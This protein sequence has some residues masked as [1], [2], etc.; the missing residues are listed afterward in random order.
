MTLETRPS[1]MIQYDH[2]WSWGDTLSL[3]IVSY[4][5]SLL[6]YISVGDCHYLSIV[7]QIKFLWG[8]WLVDYSSM[9]IDH[10]RE[11]GFQNPC[12]LSP[13]NHE[14]ESTLSLVTYPLCGLTNQQLT[15]DAHP[16]RCPS[17]C[18]NKQKNA[19]C[20]SYSGKYSSSNPSAVTLNKVI[21]ALTHP[22]FHHSLS[23]SVMSFFSKTGA[24]HKNW[25]TAAAAC[26]QMMNQTMVMP[27]PVDVHVHGHLTFALYEAYVGAFS[28][29]CV[30]HLMQ[31]V[32]CYTVQTT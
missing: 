8:L 7:V 30:N 20:I 15:P 4:N 16:P 26:F 2:W 29:D 22:G 28:H 23:A 5:V 13:E 12:A 10:M 25:G 24:D 27:R 19:M 3:S 18:V 32:P 6:L 31:T 11:G 21:L 9:M 1:L 17:V 14:C